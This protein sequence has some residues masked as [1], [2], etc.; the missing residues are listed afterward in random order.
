SG[1][2]GVLAFLFGPDSN[3]L[4][5]VRDEHLAVADLAGSGGLHD[6]GNSRVEPAIGNHQFD[7]DLRQEIHRVFTAAIDFGR[8]FL[9][10]E[11]FHFSDGHAFDAYVPKGILLFLELEWFDDR[12]DFFHLNIEFGFVQQRPAVVTDRPQAAALPPVTMKVF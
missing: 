6:R 9:A 11:T 1:S 8:A 12:F 5:D 7:F 10:P 3:G 4:F 2:D